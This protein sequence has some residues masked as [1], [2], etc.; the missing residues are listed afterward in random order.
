MNCR[1]CLWPLTLLLAGL[2]SLCGAQTLTF[3]RN[4]DIVSIAGYVNIP[5][6]CTFEARIRPTSLTQ[7]SNIWHELEGNYTDKRLGIAPTA[8]FG[9]TWPASV[10]VPFIAYA[11]LTV[12]DWHHVAYVKQG[13]T[14]SLY[15]DGNLIGTRACGQNIGNGTGGDMW[16]GGRFFDGQLYGGLIGEMD[17]VRISH[18]ARYSGASFTPPTGDL[19][20]DANTDILYNFDEPIGSSTVQDLS[21]HGHTGT[22]GI[23][24][25][26][27]TSPAFTGLPIYPDAY[28]MYRGNLL[29]GGLSELQEQDGNYLFAL[30]GNTTFASESPLQLLTEGVWTGEAP[31]S[32]LQVKVV[33][34]ASTP[35]LLQIVELYN[36][37]TS[38]WES[39]GSRALGVND[40]TFTTLVS[41]S[42][43][44]FFDQAGGIRMRIRILQFAPVVY[45]PWMVRFD[46]VH[47]QATP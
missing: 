37:N 27:A 4:T 26:G 12:G 16:L 42:L 33:A 28:S 6:D 32:S 7:D 15:L 2:A 35:G 31:P 38:T 1:F 43:G 23:G 45:S 47:W 3:S 24:Y 13:T 41:G 22:L 19:T 30:K 20:T 46:Q 17:T 9:Y 5:V 11:Q 8:V 39:V 44:R 36:L 18:V 21:G 40:G 25:T 10:T 29:R 14:E 34:A